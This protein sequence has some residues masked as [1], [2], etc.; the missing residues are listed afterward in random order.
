M[1]SGDVL[2]RFVALSKLTL[3]P[4]FAGYV[5]RGSRDNEM[6]IKLYLWEG[7][8]N[9]INGMASALATG[10]PVDL[11]WAVNEHC[12][13]QYEV[14]FE[15]LNGIDSVTNE[16]VGRYHPRLRGPSLFNFYYPVNI[17]GLEKTTYR[18]NMQAAYETICGSLF[19][20]KVKQHDHPKTGISFRQHFPAGEVFPVEPFLKVLQIDL[21]EKGVNQ[22]W[23]VADSRTQK[24]RI[25]DQLESHGI[26]CFY[27]DCQLP[28][29]DLDRDPAQ[30]E[31]FIDDL[32][33][34]HACRKFYLNNTRST[35]CDR[36]LFDE[37]AQLNFVFDDG[38]H[39]K[40]AGGEFYDFENVR[41]I[42]KRARKKQ[43]SN[44]AR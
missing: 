4:H 2:S 29:H 37:E 18:K 39:R 35:L 13:L 10:R 16:L 25:I 22:V 11:Y 8:C 15:K 23:V 42:Y 26:Q 5:E 7:L 38:K 32:F 41:I 36:F 14:L 20:G 40:K 3:S 9:R 19:R 1:V 21:K 17:D 6:S 24:E 27:N 34:L 33:G 44:E 30:M 31:N 12:P 43:V 28:E